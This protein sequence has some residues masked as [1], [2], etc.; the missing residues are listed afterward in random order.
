MFPTL[1]RS[2]LWL[3]GQDS[4]TSMDRYHSPRKHPPPC[5]TLHKTNVC[6]IRSKAFKKK[7]MLTH[8]ASLYYSK[9]SILLLALSQQEQFLCSTHSQKNWWTSLSFSSHLGKNYFC[10]VD[11]H[12]NIINKRNFVS[13]A[14]CSQAPQIM[15]QILRFIPCGKCT[16]GKNTTVEKPG[17]T[18]E[19]HSPIAHSKTWFK[20]MHQ[21]LKFRYQDSNFL[22]SRERL[23]LPTELQ[24]K[25]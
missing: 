6:I 13:A 8:Y 11:Y 14:P 5:W 15:S 10:S 25:A 3:A 22:G 24:K 23:P 19:G 2:Y 20:F 4:S 17:S 12:A 21:R 7:K 9:L 16:T 1:L 18:S